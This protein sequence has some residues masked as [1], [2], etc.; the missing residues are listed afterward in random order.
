MD[1]AV[2]EDEVKPLVN[3]AKR[4][5]TTRPKSRLPENRRNVQFNESQKLDAISQEH[6][7]VDFFFNDVK[8]VDSNK[9]AGKLSSTVDR[10][11]CQFSILAL[12]ANPLLSQPDLPEAHLS[13]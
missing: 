13:K 3:L 2:F 7:D 1:N 4:R 12:T 11:K 10:L 6:L 8:Y 5:V 9:Q